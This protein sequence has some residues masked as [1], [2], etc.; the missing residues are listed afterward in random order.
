MPKTIDHVR[1]AADQPEDLAEADEGLGLLSAD[2]A[3]ALGQSGPVL[4]ASGSTGTCAGGAVPR[5]RE[6]D[7]DVPV[8]HNGDVYDRYRV[9]VDEMRESVKIIQQCLEGM[10]AA[11]GS[12]TTG[13][14][15]CRRGTSS[16]PRWSR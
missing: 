14:S 4:R 12:P 2:D 15:C 8:Y 16:T 9:R 1:D 6:L 3:I 7:F 11:R 10:P 13:R 5:L